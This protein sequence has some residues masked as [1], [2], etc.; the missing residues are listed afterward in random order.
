M[1][2]NAASAR[3]ESEAEILFHY[4]NKVP[5]I[6]PRANPVSG[7][8]VRSFPA[9]FSAPSAFIWALCSDL[10][11]VLT[12]QE[13][14]AYFAARLSRRAITSRAIISAVATSSTTT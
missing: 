9:I 14:A 3:G 7:V 13:R 4:R 1:C 12:A 11:A 10:A 5:K 6:S 8:T 2:V